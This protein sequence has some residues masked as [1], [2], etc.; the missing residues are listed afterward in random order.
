MALACMLWASHMVAVRVLVMRGVLA[1]VL[2][3]DCMADSTE[4]WPS[5]CLEG[6]FSMHALINW[7]S[8]RGLADGALW[9]QLASLK[10]QMTAKRKALK[11]ALASLRKAR[12]KVALG[13]L[14]RLTR[15]MHRAPLCTL[16]DQPTLLLLACLR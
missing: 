7:L 6:L 8:T 1:A 9:L 14:V 12:S 4:S 2:H 3:V 13:Q 15:C 10:L 11:A 16:L 5:D